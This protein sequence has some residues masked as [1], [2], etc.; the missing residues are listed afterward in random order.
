MGLGGRIGGCGRLVVDGPIRAGTHVSVDSVDAALEVQSGGRRK[1]R[2]FDR[3]GV[4]LICPGRERQLDEMDLPPLQRL[5][6]LDLREAPQ[7]PPREFDLDTQRRHARLR[8]V[9]RDE[10]IEMLERAPLDRARILGRARPG[11]LFTPPPL[12]RGVDEGA[13]AA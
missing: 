9:R 7:S 2:R 12:E 6:G 8:I 1:P 10:A 13:E 3:A 5:F 4:F 11:G